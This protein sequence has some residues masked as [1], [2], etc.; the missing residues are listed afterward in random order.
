M[1]HTGGVTGDCICA[2]AVTEQNVGHSINWGVSTEF[3]VQSSVDESSS[4]GALD[5]VEYTIKQYESG[6]ITDLRAGSVN[7]GDPAITELYA[8]IEATYVVNALYFFDDGAV[9]VT[10]TI[11]ELRTGGVTTILSWKTPIATLNDG[12]RNMTIDNP[13]FTADGRSLSPIFTDPAVNV[14]AVGTLFTGEIPDAAMSPTGDVITIVQIG[15]L[16]Y[17]EWTDLPPAGGLLAG[18]ACYMPNCV[19]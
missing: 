3:I 13:D 2:F 1:L 16:D 17:G 10:E 18:F 15:I 4:T 12:C 9:S 19:E 11:L 8:S 5:H 14:L 6:V 7:A